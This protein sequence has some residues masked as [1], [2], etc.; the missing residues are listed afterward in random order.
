MCSCCILFTD[1]L[2]IQKWLFA[3]LAVVSP[4]DMPHI[5]S[6]TSLKKHIFGDVGANRQASTQKCIGIYIH[7]YTYTCIYIC[8]FSVY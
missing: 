3:G 5:L 2:A 4:I 7:I 1:L 8:V 6:H